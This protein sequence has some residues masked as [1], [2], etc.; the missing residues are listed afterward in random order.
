MNKWD[1]R[2]LELAKQVG[3]WSKDPSTQAGAVIV[4]QRNRIVSVGFNGF[5]A[6]I[7][8]DERLNNREDKYPLVIHAEMN[9]QLFAKQDLEGCTVYTYP[10]PPCSR[11]ASVLVQVDIARVVFPGGPIPSRWVVDLDRAH[12]LF[13][14]ANIIVDLIPDIVM[15]KIEWVEDDPWNRGKSIS[16]WIKESHKIS[17]EHGFN[18]KSFPEAIALIHSELSEA[19]EAH[20]KEGFAVKEIKGKLEGV[21]SELADAVIRICD[22]SGRFGLDLE[23]AM[24]RK[25]SYNKTRPYK[26]GKSY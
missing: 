20:R 17:V 18:T 15:D 5:P 26:H 10:L 3:S 8:D 19:L 12:S 24:K 4:D 6:G 1:T 25:Q 9:A 11:C 21:V 7:A 22:T 2:F 14:E 16:E 13:T 23:E